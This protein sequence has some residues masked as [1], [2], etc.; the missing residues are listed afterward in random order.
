MKKILVLLFLFLNLW[1]LYAQNMQK[2]FNLLSEDQYTKAEAMFV[3]V[4]EDDK[5]NPYASFAIGLMYCDPRYA[6]HNYF[7]GYKLMLDG[8]RLYD[9]YPPETFT[10]RRKYLDKDY[11]VFAK[12]SIETK[13]F[14]F[15]KSKNRISTYDLYIKTCPDS[16][17]V[18]EVERIRNAM[19][20]NEIKDSKL[21]ADY[22]NF[23]TKYPF[24]EQTP[25]AIVKRN[26][27]AFADAMRFFS[28]KEFNGFMK[29]YPDAPQYWE[30]KR[31]RDSL[32]FE[33][34]SN[35][36]S[37]DNLEFFLKQYP[38]AKFY[39]KVKFKRD[40][41]AFAIAEETNTYA[42][43]IAFLNNY[44][45]AE[46]FELV[47]SRLYNM[48]LK[49]ALSGKSVPAIGTFLD[50]YPE[51]ENFKRVY[52]RLNDTL[53]LIYA[54]NVSRWSDTKTKL[55]G[56]T[57][58]SID[59]LP[60]NIA[61]NKL[62]ETVCAGMYHD[63]N[64]RANKLNVIKLDQY[65]QV[66]VSFTPDIDRLNAISSVALSNNE[67]I[68]VAGSY[69][70]QETD[71]SKNWIVKYDNKGTQ[72]WNR[73][74]PNLHIEQILSAENDNIW[75]IGRAKIKS[76][77]ELT[78]L[79]LNTDG[80]EITSS[81]VAVPT[82]FYKTSTA[83]GKLF[84]STATG[85]YVFDA[86]GNLTATVS[87]LGFSNKTTV[88]GGKTDEIYTAEMQWDN[89]TGKNFLAFTQLTDSGSVVQVRKV[90]AE[91]TNMVVENLQ[92]PEQ[93][94]LLISGTYSDTQSMNK[95]FILL[96]STDDAIIFSDYLGFEHS[97]NN[98]LVARNKWNRL[99]LAVARD[100]KGRMIILNYTKTFDF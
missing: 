13:M 84:L 48:L 9:D 78:V 54:G 72:Y 80:N 34:A 49:E 60:F 10:V 71:N 67:R 46:Q 52:N 37:L 95:A 6:N 91:R 99:S 81:L 73:S 21:A 42:G 87:P 56:P 86:A 17:H 5:N 11:M 65:G 85:F 100:V 25:Q 66:E 20:Y 83:S 77:K 35:P 15:V 63:A 8:I 32:A 96:V 26:E 7:A 58:T 69:S 45:S 90:P 29:S 64:L 59:F 57:N 98:V 61:R 18:P 27:L 28:P 14:M 30:A 23:V 97:V 43:Y 94:K 62:G 3:K 47:R 12:D 38:N 76:T 68:L 53:G 92:L 22:A 70:G 89:T 79:L 33:V 31:L 51:D 44:P 39:D 75:V 19:A 55:V 93:G 74:F 1:Q 4:L 41:M 82:A 16:K 50:L 2:A 40:S 88:F 24:A 36:A